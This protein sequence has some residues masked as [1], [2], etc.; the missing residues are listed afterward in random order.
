MSA[1]PHGEPAAGI[2]GLVSVVMPAYEAEEFIGEALDSVF[3]QDH[4]SVEVIVVDDGSTDRTSEIAA[5]RG[6]SVLKRPNGGPAAAR[7]T[8]IAVARGEFLAVIDADDLWPPDRLS[9]QVAYLRE[10][11]HVGIVLAL[12][13]IFLTPGQSPP[14]HHQSVDPL[15]RVPG[16]PS[17]MLVRRALFESVGPYDESLV[18][19]EDMDWLSR[20]TDSGVVLGRIEQTVLRYRIHAQNTTRDVERIKI[21]TMRVMRASVQRKRAIGA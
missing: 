18:M 11:P 10:H 19:S 20:A 12:T 5:A 4:P 2:P 17:T 3:A 13:E 9:S 15:T 14:P 16:H 1:R 6:A 7:N 8:G 21:D